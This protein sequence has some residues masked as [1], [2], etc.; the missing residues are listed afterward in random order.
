VNWK[1]TVAGLGRYAYGIAAIVLGVSGLIF[2]DFATAWQPIQAFGDNVP[3]RELYAQVAAAGELLGGVAIL[4]G[5]T[6][7]FGAILLGLLYFAFALLWVPRIVG[8]PYIFGTW[9]GFLKEFAF[10]PAA[11]ILFASTGQHN[12]LWAV[13][14]TRISWTLFGICVLSFAGDH[15][16]NIS[17]TAS[18]VP[19]WIP[20]NQTFWAMATGCAFMLAGVAILTG[21]FAQV[22]A[23]LLAAMLAVFGVL[24]WLPR[25]FADSHF[26]NAW[27][28]NAVNL[29]IAAAAWIVA[30]SIARG[31]ADVQIE[32]QSK[33]YVR[34]VL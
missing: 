23:R 17:G 27:G 5:P 20:P 4:Y 6:I 3:H 30:D 1:A 22:A 34:K 9:A 11:A 21:L 32:E 13:R 33:A 31:T 12:A 7:R 29:G 14:L 8:F 19:A 18:M 24:I 10:V 25:L 28:G 16:S 2:H 26:H 15:F